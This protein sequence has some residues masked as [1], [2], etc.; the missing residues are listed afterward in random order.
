MKISVIFTGGTIGSVTESDC[1]RLDG[2]STF[3][4]IDMYRQKYGNDISFDTYEPYNIH[5]EN[6]TTDNFSMLCSC[7]FETLKTNPD[8]II[9]THGTDTLQYTAAVLSFVFAGC[10]LPIILVSANYPL[11]DKRSNGLINFAVA[12][13]FIKRRI[14]NGVFVSYKNKSEMP[15]I[16]SAS[17]LLPHDEFSDSLRS[18]FNI[19]YGCFA[20]SCFIKNPE[21]KACS[22]S[23]PLKPVFGKGDS[24]TVVHPIPGMRYPQLSDN[25]HAVLHT[26]YHSGTLCV[27]SPEFKKF[28]GECK[29]RNIPLFLVGINPNLRQ[30]ESTLMYSELGITVLP[31]MTFF[32]AYI[33]LLLLLSDD[34]NSDSTLKEKML[35]ALNDEFI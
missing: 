28:C 27:Q 26:S 23:N 34:K 2:K 30:Y 7:I 9:I 20:N 6:L 35:S 17:R 5:S 29:E 25:I 32:S 19:T 12:A 3:K 21:Y 24:I 10:K 11:D 1:V 13:E 15:Q 33:K 16:H 22:A 8:G 14:D 18:A 4:L 31:P